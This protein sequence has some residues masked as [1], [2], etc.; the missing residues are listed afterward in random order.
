M[1]S[2]WTWGMIDE[3]NTDIC[4]TALKFVFKK[5]RKYIFCFC[6]RRDNDVDWTVPFTH[7][8]ACEF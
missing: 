7:L 3:Q 1:V 2:E 4:G 8:E 5:Q 6:Q